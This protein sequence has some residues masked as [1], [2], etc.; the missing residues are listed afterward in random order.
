M[1]WV[2]FKYQVC[3]LKDVH[4]QTQIF[5]HF[6]TVN[7]TDILQI[8][9]MTKHYNFHIITNNERTHNNKFF[10]LPLSYYQVLML[11]SI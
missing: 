8:R 1:D 6:A 4:I 10:F 9:T 11:K 3:V 7:N 5:I 2:S